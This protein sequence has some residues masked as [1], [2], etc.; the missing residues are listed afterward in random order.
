MKKELEIL[1]K[2][3]REKGLRYTP[4]REEILKVFLSLERHLSA[5]ELHKIVKKRSP[6]IGH[7]T[8]YRTMKLLSEAGLCNEVDFGDGIVRFEHRYGHEHHDHLICMKCGNY[9]EVLKP[10]IEKLQ[11]ELAKERG[12]IAIKHKLQIFGICARC[13]KKK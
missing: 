3:I 9:E 4:Q 12:F 13:A 8:V 7:V 11:D 10:E 2:H 1:E 6:G 5:D